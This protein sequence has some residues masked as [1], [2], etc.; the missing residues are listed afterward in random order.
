MERS[1]RFAG[2]LDRDRGRDAIVIGCELRR[3]SERELGKRLFDSPDV[4]VDPAGRTHSRL[5][6]EETL[7]HPGIFAVLWRFELRSAAEIHT[8]GPHLDDAAVAYVDADSVIGAD[9]INGLDLG[10]AVVLHLVICASRQNFSLYAGPLEG[11]PCDR[12]NRT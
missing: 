8:F 3:S 4:Q 7:V 9:A 10:S 5:A 1:G 11:T 6:K 2:H 12:N